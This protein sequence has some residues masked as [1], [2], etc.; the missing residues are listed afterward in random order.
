MQRF[1]K[2]GLCWGAYTLSRRVKI[3]EMWT[4]ITLTENGKI[5]VGTQRQHRE[6]QRRGASPCQLGKSV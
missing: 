5:V 6:I 1:V 4:W 2:Q 3:L